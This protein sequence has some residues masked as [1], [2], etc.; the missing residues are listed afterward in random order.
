MDT[1][2]KALVHKNESIVNVPLSNLDKEI[3]INVQNI[4]HKAKGSSGT[5]LEYLQSEALFKNFAQSKKISY[6]KYIPILDWIIGT[7]LY[8]NDLEK[9]IQKNIPN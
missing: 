5:F 7:G 1:K 9:Q 3:Q 6:V 2:G 4:I 8:T